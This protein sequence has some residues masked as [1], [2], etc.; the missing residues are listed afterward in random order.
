M[1]RL[2]TQGWPTLAAISYLQ[3][4]QSGTYEFRRRLPRA[5][6]GRPAP[7]HMNE[8]FDSLI[9][10]R[11]RCFKQEF[12][13]SLRT[14]NIEQAKTRD[15]EM[16]LHFAGLVQNAAV[17]FLPTEGHLLLT[18]ESA[19]LPS[20]APITSF[21][22]SRDTAW[23]VAHP[24]PVVSSDQPLQI[25]EQHGDKDGPLL[26]E[27]FAIWKVGGRGLPGS[28]APTTKTIGEAGLAV[29][30][31]TD[32]FGDL[33]VAN[34]TKRRAREYREAVGRVPSPLPKHL[35]KLRLPQLLDCNLTGMPP[36]N[37]KTVNKYLQ[38]M[39]GIL[40]KAEGEALL[41]GIDNFR[42]PFEK[43]I[44]LE[45]DEGEDKSREIFSKSD[46]TAIFQSP[47]FTENWRTEGGAGEAA[48]WLPLIALLNGMRLSE[49]A[50]LRLRDIHRDDHDKVWLFH[51]NRRGGRKTKTASSNR[52]IPLHPTLIRIG[53]LRYSN[54][55][56]ARGAAADDSLWPSI[57]PSAWSKWINPYLRSKCGIADRTKVFH[58]FRHTFKRMARDAKLNEE[59]HDALTG[60]ANRDSVG[61]DYGSGFSI[62]PLA[63]AMASI[64]PAINL[65]KIYWAPPR[66]SV[67]GGL[68]ALNAPNHNIR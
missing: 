66:K 55:L 53:L 22:R 54:W 61:R 68:A 1:D 42:N 32:L 44:K 37:A 33:R 24:S 48:F 3:R 13:R 56:A 67:S 64:K 41:D 39:G 23:H 34:I 10:A 47:V 60:H 5:L 45:L 59:I 11:T 50:Q 40:S 28:K 35:R 36:R 49:I 19:T 7:D 26:S 25:A 62:K 63:T 14:K 21:G 8:R 38:L 2:A 27:A 58:S 46:L 20:F 9:N 4:R 15:H 43:S 16:A 29:R 6:A 57:N 17:V 31:F 12:V 51:I 30:Y 52:R 65:N 18:T